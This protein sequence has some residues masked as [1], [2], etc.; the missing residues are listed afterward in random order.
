MISDLEWIQS[1][2][3][4]LKLTNIEAKLNKNI[5]LPI[6]LLQKVHFDPIS[7]QKQLVFLEEISDSVNSKFANK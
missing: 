1:H 4:K 6:H 2:Q 5:S 7:D 3:S